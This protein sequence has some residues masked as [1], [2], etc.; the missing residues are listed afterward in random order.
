[1][2][3]VIVLAGAWLTV[4][5][6]RRRPKRKVDCPFCLRDRFSTEKVPG[7]QV[8]LACQRHSYWKI[9]YARRGDCPA[10]HRIGA[11][12]L[13]DIDSNPLS[14]CRPHAVRW[15]RIMR[16]EKEVLGFVP[17]HPNVR[18][19]NRDQPGLVTPEDPR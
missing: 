14:L 8:P 1:M 12:I 3:A 5:L 6:P 17:G 18:I 16:L 11:V 7:W 9:R 2:F 13:A 15:A 10:C 4:N 19:V